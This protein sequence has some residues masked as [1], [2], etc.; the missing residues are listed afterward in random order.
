[1]LCKSIIESQRA[2]RAP[3]AVAPS[4]FLAGELEVW[5]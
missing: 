5:F 1:V 4:I 3:V 2:K